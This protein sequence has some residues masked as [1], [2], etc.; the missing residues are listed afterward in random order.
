M[1]GVNLLVRLGRRALAG[2]V[3]D[4]GLLPVPFYRHL[5]LDALERHD[6]PQALNYLP[7]TADPVLAQLLI[8]RLRLL[9][10]RHRQEQEALRQLAASPLPA[11]RRG[12]CRELLAQGERALELLATYEAQALELAASRAGNACRPAASN[13]GLAD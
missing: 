6:F 2:P 4:S 8:L 7:W 11:E 5:V 9:S 12:R 10:A 13:Q 1:L 3:A